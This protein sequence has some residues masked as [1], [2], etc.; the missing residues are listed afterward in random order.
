MK[1]LIPVLIFFDSNSGEG[2]EVYRLDDAD[3]AGEFFQN[4][5][6]NAETDVEHKLIIQNW[7]YEQ[8]QEAVD[9]GRYQA[10]EME[11][12]EEEKFIKRYNQRGD[13]KNET[14]NN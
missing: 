3:S 7:T 5:Q 12:D 13:K 11:P 10:G 14:T 4:L 2:P 6:H 9:L 1:T 8:W